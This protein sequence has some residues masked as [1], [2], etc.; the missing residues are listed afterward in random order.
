MRRG[1]RG[2]GQGGDQVY[3]EAYV[4]CIFG[5]FTGIR[6]QEGAGKSWVGGGD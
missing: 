1:V 6:C 2:E 4:E 3:G 5:S